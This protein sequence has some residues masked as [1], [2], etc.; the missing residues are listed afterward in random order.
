MV[1]EWDTGEWRLDMK[2]ERVDELSPEERAELHRELEEMWYGR[3]K[4]RRPML[5]CEGGQVVHEIEVN[6]GPFDPNWRVGG[7]IRIKR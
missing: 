5:I 4:P 7:R 6:V 1:N 2:P 3:R